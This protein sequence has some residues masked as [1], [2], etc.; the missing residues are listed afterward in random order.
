[1]S[2]QTIDQVQPSANVIEMTVE[3]SLSDDGSAQ[4]RV[5]WNATGQ[6]AAGMRQQ[7][8]RVGRRQQ[9]LEGVVTSL[10][11]GG[12]LTDMTFSDLMN[13][14]QPV[15]IRFDYKAAQYAERTG[16]RLILRPKRRF[17]LTERYAPRTERHYDVWLPMPSVVEY[18]EVYRF[19]PSWAIQS[20]PQPGQLDTPWMSYKLQCTGSPGQVR[21][22]KKLV[23][24]ATDIPKSE[25]ARLREF[26][27]AADKHEQKTVTLGTK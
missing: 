11:P 16:A 15:E 23:I 25:Y 13:R 20:L 19:P 4:V 27:I 1:M 3:A 5:N 22:D 7:F 17:E 6:F 10:Q 8:R 18:S 12:Q 21:I 2:F 14:D 26:C 24:K 9:Q